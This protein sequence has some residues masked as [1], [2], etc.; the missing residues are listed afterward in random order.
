VGHRQV[1]DQPLAKEGLEL[2]SEAPPQLLDGEDDVAL[3]DHHAL[4]RAGG[5]G[6]VDESGQVFR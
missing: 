4:G 3:A 5:A 1:G 2:E 6:R